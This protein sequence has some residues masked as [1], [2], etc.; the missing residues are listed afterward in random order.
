[1]YGI[2]F[3][4]FLAILPPFNGKVHRD[5]SLLFPRNLIYLWCCPQGFI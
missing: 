3:I 2:L 4:L 5:G 1:M